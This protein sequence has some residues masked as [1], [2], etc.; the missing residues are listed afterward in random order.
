MSTPPTPGTDPSATASAD[1]TRSERAGLIVEVRSDAS[2]DRWFIPA[3]VGKRVLRRPRLS[4]IP[5]SALQMTLVE[6][7][8]V[9]VVSLG[10]EATE[11]VLCTL[12]GQ[13]LAISGARVLDTGSYPACE[14][15]I[16]SPLGELA[17]LPL[18]AELERLERDP[19]GKGQQP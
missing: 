5:R 7:Q 9:A 4:P 14:I 8:V 15:G 2:R 6:G 13:Q 10:P 17:E 19:T 3:E 11:L 18:L 1:S 12:R 16:R